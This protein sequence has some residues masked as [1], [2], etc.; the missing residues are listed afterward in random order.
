[1]TTATAWPGRPLVR[2]PSLRLVGLLA[3]GAGLVVLQ[4]AVAIAYQHR[5]TWWHYLLHQVIGWGVGL[6]TAALVACVSRWRVPALVALLA[7]QLASIVPDLM[8]VYLRMPHEASMDLYLGHI[9]IHT[10]PTPMIVAVAVLLLG[11]W[12]YVAVAFGR[13]L[14]AAALGVGALVLLTVA[15]L[16]ARPLPARLSDFPTDTAPLA[17]LSR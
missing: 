10:G 2:S 17:A 8:F 4:V 14:T 16:V 6:A 9:S 11:G 5:G 15:C 13:R 3:G 1:M 12:A 7:G